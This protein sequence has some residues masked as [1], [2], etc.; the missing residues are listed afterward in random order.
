MEPRRRTAR[1][2]I[3]LGIIGSVAFVIGSLTLWVRW[4]AERRWAEMK[5][6]LLKV[7]HAEM[8][9]PT[10][11]PVLR[12]TSE[13][14]NAWDDYDQAI[15]TIGRMKAF[16][17]S[18]LDSYYHAGI[19][20][21]ARPPVLPGRKKME[22]ILAPFEP[23]LTHLRNGARRARAQF[24]SRDVNGVEIR[25]LKGYLSAGLGHFAAVRARFLADDG[26]ARGAAELLLDFG[27]L[28]R[29]VSHAEH[30]LVKYSW[31]NLQDVLLEELGALVRSGRLPPEMLLQVDRELE[32][33][34]GSSR[35]FGPMDPTDLLR[36]GFGY[37]EAD[38]LFREIRSGNNDDGDRITPW[39]AWRFGFSDR[40]MV[41]DALAEGSDWLRACDPLRSAPWGE[42]QLAQRE[43]EERSKSSPNPV[44][45]SHVRWAGNWWPI[46][47]IARARL[48]LLRMAAVHKATGEFLE[49]EDPFGG[50]LRHAEIGCRYKLWSVG[51][52]GKDDGGDGAWKPG[53]TLIKD[54]VLEI[55]R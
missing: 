11:R 13:P 30:R 41:A 10:E 53:S 39:G 54:I 23:S 14:G 26:R 43:F 34:D 4:A 15:A 38:N 8:A 19:P 45:R 6:G 29:D 18:L 51:R 55:E 5:S 47:R 27:Q 16:D 1:W 36:L 24:H 17:R 46:T 28:A 40:L 22:S 25:S 44:V 32:I 12:G 48:R 37:L 20:N 33:L 21:A 31:S 2:K 3:L 7:L 52:D 9:R 35:P 50:T 42:V 49:L